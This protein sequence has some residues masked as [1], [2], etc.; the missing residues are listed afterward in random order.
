MGNILDIIKNIKYL[1]LTEIEKY[2]I[3]I[4]DESECVMHKSLYIHYIYNDYITFNI[5]LLTNDLIFDYSHIWNYGTCISNDIW[6]K[7]IIKILWQYKGI[8]INKI[9]F[10]DT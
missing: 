5:C 8:R 6:E 4:I 7:S 1:R 10:D 2:L 9:T 3:R